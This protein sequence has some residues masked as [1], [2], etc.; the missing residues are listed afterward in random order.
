MDKE[1]IL[2]LNTWLECEDKR[3]DNY[4]T[5]VLAGHGMFSSY[6][7]G[8]GKA[9]GDECIYCQNT[10]T[11]EHTLFNCKQWESLRQATNRK[12]ADA[13]TSKTIV[14]TLL[15]YSSSC[16]FTATYFL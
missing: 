2:D 10:D 16:Y 1:L 3:I 14:D 9:V 6:T 15:R 5:Q 8:I 11:A 12:V 4:L 7:K 13:I